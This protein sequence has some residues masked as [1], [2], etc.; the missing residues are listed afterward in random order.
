MQQG[1]GVGAVGWGEH[2]QGAARVRRERRG[3]TVCRARWAAHKRA[4]PTRTQHGEDGDD[5]YRHRLGQLLPLEVHGCSCT[6][7]G[8]RAARAGKRT[9]GSGGGGGGSSGGGPIECRQAV[10]AIHGSTQGSDKHPGASPEQRKRL[11]RAAGRPGLPRASSRGLT[12]RI[13][14]TGCC[15]NGRWLPNRSCRSKLR[16]AASSALL[17]LSDRLQ[18]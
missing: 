2:P 1:S 8:W 13:S 10:S 18:R 12:S 7:Q 14:S 3:W 17:G 15:C 4:W 5:P 16:Q 6:G 11:E 9:L